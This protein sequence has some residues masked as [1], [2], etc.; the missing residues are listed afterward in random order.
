MNQARAL[1][2]VAVTVRGHGPREASAATG[3]LTPPR[4]RNDAL[5]FTKGSLVLI[6]V[7]Y[8][9]LNYF[10]DLQWDVYRYLRFLTPSFI[11]ISGFIVSAIYPVKRFGHDSKIR[12]RLWQ[13]G[14][15]LL[16]L[17][18]ILNLGIS[19][20]GSASSG[21]SGAPPWAFVS[22]AYA[23]Y[24]TGNGRASFEI[25]VPIAYFLLLAPFALAAAARWKHAVP[26]A[27]TGLLG[28]A[29]V[30]S[31]RGVPIA[32]LE[33]IAIA[34]LGMLAGSVSID[35]V[36]WRF[37]E[38]G[39]WMTAYVG[40]LVAI[41]IWN[42][43]FPLQ[44]AGVCLSVLGLYLLG[45]RAGA[46]GPLQRL[47]ILLGQYSLFAYV[48]QVAILQ[49]LQRGLSDDFV[50]PARVWVPFVATLI[51][52]IGSVEIVAKARVRIRLFDRLYRA[53]FA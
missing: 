52:M 42:I 15:K 21:A 31:L 14:G 44:I 48:G 49:A 2:P 26:I 39:W 23:I 18:T 1:S 19:A 34:F 46:S 30:A 28:V 51:L 53:V 10:V 36:G 32:N 50:V 45:V 33:L 17:F 9:W 43:L 37:R 7:V 27:A 40:Y 25:L 22:E 6:M 13:R 8:H 3:T 35:R 41:T 24:V 47:T 16:A 29:C 38:P 5:D 12:R 11:F 4:R 20:L